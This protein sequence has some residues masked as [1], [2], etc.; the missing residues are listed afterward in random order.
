MNNL[1]RESQD[2]SLLNGVPYQAAYKPMRKSRRW[3][4]LAPTT[5]A[6]AMAV[7]L[8]S[9]AVSPAHRSTA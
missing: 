1:I 6:L 3:R 9:R 2:D 5:L 7:M 8:P 4:W